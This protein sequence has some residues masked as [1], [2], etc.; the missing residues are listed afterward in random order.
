MISIVSEPRLGF[1]GLSWQERVYAKIGKAIPVRDI[2]RIQSAYRV[3][4]QTVKNAKYWSASSP[5]TVMARAIATTVPP[6]SPAGVS[7]VLGAIETLARTGK[8]G[9]SVWDTAQEKT[10]LQKALSPAV[11]TLS[12]ASKSAGNIA[13]NVTSPVQGLIIKI[14]IVA[15]GAG[16]GYLLLKKKLF[17]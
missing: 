7:S 10:L 5:D 14:A 16:V 2:T 8:I 11:E 13:K 1:L 6:I 15:A 3:Y 12:I 9:I 17:S 4:L